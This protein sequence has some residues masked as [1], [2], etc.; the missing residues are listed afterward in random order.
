MVSNMKDIESLFFS[1]KFL[2]ISKNSEIEKT[3]FRDFRISITCDGKWEDGEFIN[4]Y[5]YSL[6]FSLF[7]DTLF[8]NFSLASHI[9]PRKLNNDSAG[10]LCMVSSQIEEIDG[11][12]VFWLDGEAVD[13]SEFLESFSKVTSMQVFY[14]EVYL[15]NNAYF[16]WIEGVWV[17][18]YL[19]LGMECSV[20]EIMN[21]YK[22]PRM[23]I[24]S[25]QWRLKANFDTE[26]LV[27]VIKRII[28]AGLFP[29]KKPA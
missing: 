15:R 4:I 25:K 9:L 19:L 8:S 6:E 24:I 20:D 11:K 12:Y 1:N 2:K 21:Q 17:F 26:E 27:F 5:I 14:E 22:S 10:C 7:M 29:T 28:D 18:L 13:V 16:I 3:L 23:Q